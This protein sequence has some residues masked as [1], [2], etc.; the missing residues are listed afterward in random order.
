MMC[1]VVVS[2]GMGVLSLLKRRCLLRWVGTP[3]VSEVVGRVEAFGETFQ[4]A[5]VA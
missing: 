4:E 3:G 5:T 1:K 2:P